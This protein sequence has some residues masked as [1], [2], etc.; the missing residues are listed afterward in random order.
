MVAVAMAQAALSAPG[1]QAQSRRLA[2]QRLSRL[3]CKRIN[4]SRSTSNR[5]HSLKEKVMRLKSAG[6][7]LTLALLLILAALSGCSKSANVASGERTDAQLAGDVQTRISSDPSLSGRQISIN[8]DKGVVTLSGTVNSDAEVTSALNDA[9]QA[10]GVKQ[11]VSR[12]AVQTA[13]AAPEPEQKQPAP[14]RSSP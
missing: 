8:A 9:Q 12:L 4:G 14:R 2:P 5:G 3:R 7:V 10:Q 11:V 6:A 13:S 1:T